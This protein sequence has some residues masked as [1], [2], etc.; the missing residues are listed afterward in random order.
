M[1]RNAF[2]RDIRSRAVYG[3][4]HRR[5]F[6]FWIEVRGRRDPD[7][8]HNSSAQIGKDVPEKVRSHHHIEPVR[9]TNKMCGEDVDVELVAT[10]VAKFGAHRGETL[11]PK[12]HCVHDSI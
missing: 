1:I 6:P 3:F 7:R 2:T 12:R 11:I 8:T 10:H 9:M 4:K 5:K